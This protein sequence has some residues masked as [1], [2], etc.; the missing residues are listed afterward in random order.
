M[1]S[2]CSTSLLGKD[3]RNVQTLRPKL[4]RDSKPSLAQISEIRREGKVGEEW[5]LGGLFI[6]YICQAVERTWAF[7]G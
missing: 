4:S 3:Q 1:R 5:D 6:P 2:L 7:Q